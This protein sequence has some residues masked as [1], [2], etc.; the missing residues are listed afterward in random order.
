MQAEVTIC[1]ELF[2]DRMLMG[3]NMFDMFLLKIVICVLFL[4][5]I[6]AMISG[7]FKVS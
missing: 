3:R 5:I 1:V 2:K 7:M 6:I 4:L